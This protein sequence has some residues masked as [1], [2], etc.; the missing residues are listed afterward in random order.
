MK[1]KYEKNFI[2]FILNIKKKI[3][4]DKILSFYLI[5][6]NRNDILFLMKKK[7]LFLNNCFFKKIY[8]NNNYF[9]K[10]YFFDFLNKVIIFNLKKFIN[11]I[12]EDDLIIII[13]K[14][15]GISIHPNFMNWN[16]NLV[17]S[18]ISY[19]GN[20]V[21]FLFRFGILHRLDKNTSGIVLLFKKNNIYLNLIRQIK[22]NI[23]TKYYIS[24]N[25]NNINNYIFLNKIIGYINNFYKKIYK[26]LN[27]FSITNFFFFRYIIYKNFIFF[28]LKSKLITGRTHQLRTH[29]KYFNIPIIGDDFFLNN[30]IFLKKNN[31]L[32][33]YNLN[34]FHPIKNINLNFKISLS[35]DI[36]NFLNFIFRDGGIWTLDSN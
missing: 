5:Y 32:H 13:N 19:Y 8:I 20:K 23:F 33:C 12:Y 11:I 15:V 4:I 14:P 24:L 6:F 27:F 31:F 36:L 16:N 30:N 2:F 9:I 21:L 29:F 18:L 35:N 22:Y 1:F 25:L 10:I 17:N 26:N 7:F 28:F 34:F 3:R